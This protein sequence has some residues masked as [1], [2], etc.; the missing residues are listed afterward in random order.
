MNWKMFGLVGAWNGI[1]ALRVSVCALKERMYCP[2]A[3]NIVLGGVHLLAFLS[4]LSV[5]LWREKLRILAHAYLV[6]YL[7]V[8]LV[9]GCVLSRSLTHL[10]FA[11]LYGLGLKSREGK[12]CTCGKEDSD[13]GN[14]SKHGWI[15]W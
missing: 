9:V 4:V 8:W 12:V 11:F 6:S 1:G 15:C 5:C 13:G 10:L 3:V 2:W 7:S 14:A